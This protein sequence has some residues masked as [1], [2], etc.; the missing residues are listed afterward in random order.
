MSK[1]A[2]LKNNI[3]VDV[4]EIETED[5]VR[6]LIAI[7]DMVIDVTDQS[8]IPAKGYIL[9]G[10]ILE[11]PQNGTS[12]E[13]FEIDLNDRKCQFGAEICRDAV[14]KL[15]ARNK[16]LSK[17]GPQVI[18]LLTQLLAVKSLLETGA[19]GTARATCVQLK[20]VYTEYSDIF[21]FVITKV[22]EFE[23]SFGL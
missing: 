2:L 7:N 15:G 11:I 3:V 14:N 10:S 1:F 17:S 13:Q 19:L 16:I 5:E 18:A 6:A 8:P 21:D 22:N 20:V 9:N 12:R 4:V 23:A